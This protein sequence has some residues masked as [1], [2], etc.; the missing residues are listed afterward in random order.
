MHLELDHKDESAIDYG[1]IVFY[2]CSKHCDAAN[3]GKYSEEWFFKQ[4][5][6]LAGVGDGIRR[7]AQKTDSTEISTAQEK[8]I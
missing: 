2:T 7:D 1:T 8:E 5:F 4:D 6:S 3:D